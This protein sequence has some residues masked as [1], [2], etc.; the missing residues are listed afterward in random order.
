MTTFDWVLKRDEVTAVSQRDA[1]LGVPAAWPDWLPQEAAERIVGAGIPVPWRHQVEFADALFHGE[2]A[3]VCTPTGS[4]K[5]LGYLMP[6]VAAAVH[7]QVGVTVDS[8]RARLTRPRHT[9][10]YL[11]PTKALA[12]DQ[13]R[14]ASLLGPRSWR[15]TPLDGDSDEV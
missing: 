15:S 12:H 11:S 6:I 3:I 14:A 5:S 13:A 10:L 7:G 1:A 8:T 2:H 4:G 9:A